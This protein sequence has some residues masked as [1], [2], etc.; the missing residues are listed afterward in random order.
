[1][2]VHEHFGWKTLRRLLGTHK[3]IILKL[4]KND[5]MNV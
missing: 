3:R 5:D 2:E 1:M 4:F